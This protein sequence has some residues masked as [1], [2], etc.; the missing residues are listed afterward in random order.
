MSFLSLLFC[1]WSILRHKIDQKSDQIRDQFCGPFSDPFWLLL[2]LF[3][4]PRFGHVGDFSA[5]NGGWGAVDATSRP[6]RKFSGSVGGVLGA[7]CG[8]SWGIL[9]SKI[10][11]CWVH[12]GHKIDFLRSRGQS[13]TGMI[14]NSFKGRLGT[15][16]GTILGSKMN[17]KS[18][19]NRSQERSWHKNTHP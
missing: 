17:P 6:E 2:A 15:D 19:Q 5:N 14:S 16:F 13:K 10:G 8:A 11:P 3:S 9:G 7:S 4:G 18:V 1:I 12:V